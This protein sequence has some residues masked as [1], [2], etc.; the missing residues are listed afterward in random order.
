MTSDIQFQLKHDSFSLISKV[1]IVLLTDV[2]DIC[3][4]HGQYM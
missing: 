3:L 1:S 2:H 4:R